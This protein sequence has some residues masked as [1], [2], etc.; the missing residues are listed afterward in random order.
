M[1]LSDMVIS[2]KKS[3]NYKN[4]GMI[5]C[6]SGIVRGTSRDGRL[7]A[8]LEVKADHKRLKDAILE[9]KQKKGIVD[10]LAEVY[11]GR[12]KIG[13]EIMCVVVAGDVRENTFPVLAETVDA[14]KR[15]VIVEKEIR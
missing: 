13:E 5:V 1:G 4:V 2:I 7:V 10:V 9:M 6:H 3:S 15:F 12:L 14:I 8:E 11:E